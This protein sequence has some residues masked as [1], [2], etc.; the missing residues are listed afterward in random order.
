MAKTIER[1]YP[2]NP[3]TPTAGVMPRY[4]AGHEA[5]MDDFLEGL[6]EGPGA[7]ERLM[8][9][10]GLRGMGKTSMLQRMGRA[11][12]ELGWVTVD[13]T[14]KSKHLTDDLL[15]QLSL[16]GAQ[17]GSLSVTAA[18]GPV[19]ASY[20]TRRSDSNDLRGA[21]RRI[22]AK[23]G[24]K[25]LITI[26]E[27]Q[28]GSADDM[29][30]LSIAYQ[31]TV[32][33]GANIALVFAG[34]PSPVGLLMDKAELT[35]L[36]RAIPVTLEKVDKVSVEE[37]MEDTFLS[38]GV[39]VD[40][41]ALGAMADASAGYPFM[42]QHIGHQV[43]RAAKRRNPS[44]PN[45]VTVP[46]VEEALPL[47]KRRFEDTV[48][49]PALTGLSDAA[50]RY[51]CAMAVTADGEGRSRTSEVASA[52]GVKASSLSGTRARLMALDLIESP[53]RGSLCFA[54]PYMAGYLSKEAPR[55]LRRKN[56]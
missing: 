53:A 24:S 30:E 15:A 1:D 44:M 50:L 47:A 35:F 42:I 36:R 41:D 33:E 32:R 54:L 12:Q 5:V 39:S 34:L 28:A 3:F 27:V 38:E 56:R 49:V 18:V 25:V 22:T 51:L 19:R 29:S 16:K 4:W 6:Y 48:V 45:R 10:T 37:A 31:H 14:A 20:T 55:I 9:I 7:P 13:V 40:R 23:S 26:D 43:W 2:R 21:L 52:L 46:D 8:R 17:E 11:A